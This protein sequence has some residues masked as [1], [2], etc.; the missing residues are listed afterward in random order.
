MECCAVVLWQQCWM[1]IAGWALSKQDPPLEALSSTNPSNA[2]VDRPVVG[3][4]H[5]NELMAV[6]LWRTLRYF[7][8]TDA[9]D[10]DPPPPPVTAVRA[11]P[12]RHPSRLR[13]PAARTPPRA[14]QTTLAPASRGSFNQPPRCPA[15]NG[16]MQGGRR[17]RFPPSESMAHTESFQ[18][19]S[20]ELCAR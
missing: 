16:A 1:P 9:Q 11:R 20:S 10:S 6:F 12:R 14:S 4:T 17:I 15:L 18:A 7:A 19:L 13:A 8:T 3:P 5:S 2:R